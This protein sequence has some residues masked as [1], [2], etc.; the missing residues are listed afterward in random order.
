M[1]VFQV[2]WGVFNCKINTMHIYFTLS[3]LRKI[4]YICDN[5]NNALVNVQKNIQFLYREKGK[6]YKIVRCSD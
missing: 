4:V 1:L 5:R 6:G 3:L 2:I